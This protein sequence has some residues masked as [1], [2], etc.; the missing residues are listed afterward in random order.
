MELDEYKQKLAEVD[1]FYQFAE[2]SDYT[3]GERRFEMMRQLGKVLGG[4]HLQAWKDAYDR[5][6]GKEPKHGT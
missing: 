5:A 1:W 2:G 6:H 4:E 3:R